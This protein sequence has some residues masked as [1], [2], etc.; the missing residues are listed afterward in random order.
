M[1][2]P[3][4][5]KSSSKK[6]RKSKSQGKI[7]PTLLTLACLAVA[8]FGGKTL[9]EDTPGPQATSSVTVEEDTSATSSLTVPTEEEPAESAAVTETVP[10]STG[11]SALTVY[12]IDVGQGDCELLESDGDYFL[13]DAGG[14]KD[15]KTTV[16]TF[17]TDLGVES[18]SYVIA[19]H[20]HADHIQEM[21]AIVNT[22]DI[23]TFLLPDVTTSTAT[24]EKLVDALDS[25][26]VDVEAPEPG[27]TFS[28][29]SCT[30]QVLGPV[31][32]TEDD[33]NASSLVVRV[34]CG[35]TSFLFT[36]DCT[37]E[38][39]ADIL[40]WAE[41]NAATLDCD[42]LKVAHHGSYTSSSEE[43]LSAVS[44]SSVVISCGVGNS[45]GHPHQVI[46]DR[47]ATF[48]PD[49]YRTDTMG[50]ITAQSD[51]TNIT[52]TTQQEDSQ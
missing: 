11:D 7:L 23:G 51:G 27:D 16:E 29:G 17:L 8:L 39:E 18:L 37:A 48:S 44:P 1:S 42:V 21:T 43:F 30:V 24:F 5:K 36:G 33:L 25:R 41:T 20:P 45:Y 34:T 35:E 32:P 14:D 28:F 2:Q 26:N 22:W 40:S 15:H 47:L 10:S 3:R 12:Y 9:L 19:T 49:I 52:F 4:R 38:E 46:L 50:T 6:K 13:I 31:N